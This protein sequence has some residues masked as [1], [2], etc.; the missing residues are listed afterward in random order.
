MKKQLENLSLEKH[1]QKGLQRWPTKE[2][3]FIDVYIYSYSVLHQRTSWNNL[4]QASGP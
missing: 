2:S 1:F 3:G 4:N